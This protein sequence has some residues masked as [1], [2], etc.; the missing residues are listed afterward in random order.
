MNNY[1]KL[2][3]AI[4]LLVTMHSCA[5]TKTVREANTAIPDKYNIVV[6][7]TTNSAKMIWKDFFHD[8]NL[9]ALI[10]T[11]LS[12]NQELNIAMQQIAVAKNE[13]KTRKGE[14]LPFVNFGASAEV[15]RVG[16]FTRNGAVEENL[17]IREG[18][19]F[20]T[21]L[22]N[23]Q[24]GLFASWEVDVWK[25][26]RNSKK[27]ALM[28]Y[29]ASVEGRNFMVTNLVA[30]IADAY[31]ELEALDSQL[32]I[33]DQNIAIQQN[34]LDIVRL[35]KQA[36]RLTELAVKRFEAEVLKNKSERYVIKQEVVQVEN[37]L[38]FLL[39]RQP[40][41]ITRDSNTFLE[42]KI[43]TI[44]AGIPA[45]LL[46]N[47][48]DIRRAELELAANK[49]NVKVARA[50]FYPSIGISAGVGL[51]AF[52]PRFLTETPESLLYSLAGD[53]IGPL[54]NR[55]ALKAAYNTANARQLQAVFEYEKAILNGYIE[56]ATGLSNLEN[57]QQNYSLKEKQVEALTAS[58][59]I[60]NKLFQAARADYNEVLFTQR[61]ALESKMELVETKKDQLLA[62]VNVYRALGGGWN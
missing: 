60:S 14:Y 40:K 23:Y 15:E 3:A 18:E 35:Q 45:Q 44:Y 10:D 32:N 13:V 4:F 38:N 25:K 58:I 39:G 48:P 8:A 5:P 29:L 24:V 52:R 37:E 6:T 59:D 11:A 57:L 30:E 36:A 51:E 61:D 42:S 12:N 2:I 41:A 27:A 21:R 26:L 56:V 47:R 34:A 16:E 53:I 22:P 28:E 7:D 55:N 62:R 33:L 1:I 31:Y 50:N 46:K 17:P 20:P 9:N 54:I 19:A 43:D 49:L